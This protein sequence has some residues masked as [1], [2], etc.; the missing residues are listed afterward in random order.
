M[1]ERPAPLL[2]D[3]IWPGF[4]TIDPPEN[5]EDGDSVAEDVLAAFGIPLDGEGG[6]PL[7]GV[8]IKR[9][10]AFSILKSSLLEVFATKDNSLLQ[11]V[12]INPE[13]VAEFYQVGERSSY[14]SPY[15]TIPAKNNIKNPEKVS[16]M[17][18][19]KKPKQTRQIY[20]WYPLIGGTTPVDQYTI[21]DT[22]KL[23][24]ACLVLFII[25]S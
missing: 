19:G 14:L 3:D 17:V 21:Y 7:L 25:A 6:G 5:E 13:G 8:D 11:E 9:G 1:V 4:Q 18:T 22:T 12:R 16:V 2:S 24:T 15:Y 20:E 23:S 10:D